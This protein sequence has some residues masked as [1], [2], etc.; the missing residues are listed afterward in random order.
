MARRSEAAV[1]RTLRDQFGLTGRVADAALDALTD[2]GFN[3]SVNTLGPYSEWVTS[4]RL[5][6]VLDE[7]EAVQD[8][9]ARAES[10]LPDVAHE[11]FLEARI[12]SSGVLDDYEGIDEEYDFYPGE[13]IE[14]TFTYE[15]KK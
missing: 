12:L 3:P 5:F 7:V 13:E 1:L 15:E 11:R 14:I 4:G 8:E 2:E 9:L 6:D 10:L